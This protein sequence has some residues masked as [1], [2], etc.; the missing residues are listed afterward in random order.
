VKCSL[1]TLSSF[2]DGELGGDRR[3][4]VDAHLVGC[5]RCS[6]GASTLRE[7]KARV[8]QLA[9]V[10]V[11]AESAQ[12]MLEQVGIVSPSVIPRPL[13]V[14]SAASDGAWPPAS[15]APA[16]WTPSVST[17][18]SAAIEE[19]PEPAQSF[20]AQPDLFGGVAAAPGT[21]LAPVAS[22]L[23]APSAAGT[24]PEI[25]PPAGATVTDPVWLDDAAPSVSWEADLPPPLEDVP[26]A[27][28][29]WDAPI[30]STAEPVPVVAS[31]PPAVPPPMPAPA[32]VRAPAVAGPVGLLG[33][34]RDA[35]AVRLALARGR[36]AI[37][38]S[39]RIVSG[40]AP[41][42]LPVPAPPLA[43]RAYD[44]A[45]T[46]TPPIAAT[47]AGHPV[48]AAGEQPSVE[49]SGRRGVGVPAHAAR[50]ASSSSAAME[51]GAAQPPTRPPLPPAAPKPGHAG[52]SAD[53]EG[54]HAFAA[55][56]YPAVPEAEPAAR[57]SPKLGRHSRAV[58]RDGVGPGSRL[59]AL[60]A[61]LGTA[62]R[63]RT[64]SVAGA[65]RGRT[66]RLTAG[67]P[68]SRVLAGVAGIGLIFVIALLL[69]HSGAPA[70][71]SSSTHAAPPTAAVQPQHSAAQPPATPAPTVATAPTTAP[72]A[73]QVFG[74]GATGFDVSRLRYGKQAAFMR[75]VFD[76]G[77]VG[78]AQ[79]G[80]PK[81]TVAFSDPKTV[82]VT[83]A[84]TAPSASV[85]TPPSGTIISSVTLVSSSAGRSEYRIVLTRAATATAFFLLSPTRF[86]LDLH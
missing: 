20:D 6:A 62:I 29:A 21:P 17:A 37:D 40:P 78:A 32:P 74:S 51:T 35:V 26:A 10:R 65:V 39:T 61:A 22:G 2:I 27:G 3:A 15:I 50:P 45:A 38:D 44:L 56:S 7:E 81:I 71:T 70:R 41:R 12:L 68:D 53:S 52:E 18:D 25:A 31:A 4:E 14:P 19:M 24:E 48:A 80:T 66:G 82:L 49:L 75:V 33:R 79:A 47:S 60:L 11:D 58:A 28:V 76:I 72:V 63:L 43:S 77:S 30:T 69:G 23:A 85:G 73:T 64:T 42:G 55:S 5:P 46:T 8:G 1:L 84:G 59:S 67:G 9:R 57:P 86:V 34:V 16:P 13:A 36:D 54:W 83:L